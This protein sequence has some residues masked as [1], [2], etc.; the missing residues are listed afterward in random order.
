M[1]ETLGG[2]CG[3]CLR[4]FECEE[5]VYYTWYENSFFCESCKQIMNTRVTP[6]YLDWQLRKVVFSEK[7]DS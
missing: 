3:E 7:A 2:Y 5:V 1:K 4:E 6:A